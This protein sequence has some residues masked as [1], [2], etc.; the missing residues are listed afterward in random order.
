MRLISTMTEISLTNEAEV[1]TRTLVNHGDG[2]QTFDIT[3]EDQTPELLAMTT[4][5]LTMTRGQARAMLT[6]L[7]NAID[8]WDDEKAFRAVAP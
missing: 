8:A 4:L 1:S 3:F 2:K 5:R 6:G 7:A